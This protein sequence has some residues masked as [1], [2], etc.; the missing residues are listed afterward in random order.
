VIRYKIQSL[1]G[2][3]AEMLAVARGEKPAPSDA[4]LPSFESVDVL[5]RLLT[6]ENRRLLK[7]IRDA[8]PRSI[9]ELERLTGRKGPNLLRTLGKLAA[10]GLVQLR[11]E[12][13]RTVPTVLVGKLR[14]EIDPY[15]MNDRVEVA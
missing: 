4:A 9:A 3:E 14:V 6:P 7:T 11:E 1:D 10:I 15:A 12:G 2:L 8:R 5:I 13:R